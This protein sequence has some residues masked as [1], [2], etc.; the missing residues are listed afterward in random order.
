MYFRCM[1]AW[2]WYQWSP[3]LTRPHGAF[4]ENSRWAVPPPPPPPPPGRSW[5]LSSA[6]GGG[7]RSGG[8]PRCRPSQPASS[9]AVFP[10]VWAILLVEKNLSLSP[11][12]AAIDLRFSLYRT[13]ALSAR[14]TRTGTLLSSLTH[15]HA[16][17]LRCTVVQTRRGRTALPTFSWDRADLA[18]SPASSVLQRA[19]LSLSLSLLLAVRGASSFFVSLL[20][21]SLSPSRSPPPTAVPRCAELCTRERALLLSLSPSHLLRRAS[22]YTYTHARDSHGRRKS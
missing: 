14:R 1:N 16:R 7:P 10:R 18:P 4:S 11:A 15:T 9:K 2:L 21:F 17:P 5:S 3:T 8:W 20:C 6:A 12:A 13:H 22:L 19:L